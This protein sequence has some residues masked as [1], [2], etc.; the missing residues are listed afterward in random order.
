MG[1]II[2]ECGRCGEEFEDS[3]DE[4]PSCGNDLRA[5]YKSKWD[6]EKEIKNY[7]TRCGHEIGDIKLKFSL[8]VLT[9]G[10]PQC[11]KPW[12]PTDTGKFCIQCGTEITRSDR[13]CHIC[14]GKIRT[15]SDNPSPDMITT[16]KY[17]LLRSAVREY[18]ERVKQSGKD[19]DTTELTKLLDQI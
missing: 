6:K 15:P 9:K 12:S 13:K 7:C 4:C 19:A 17:Q 11:L 16:I 18:M 5:N 10:C 14:R 3:P 8:G 1:K 2:S